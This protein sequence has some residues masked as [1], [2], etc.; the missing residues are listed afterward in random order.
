MYWFSFKNEKEA[1]KFAELLNA[2]RIYATDEKDNI[3]LKSGSS[4]DCVDRMRNELNTFAENFVENDDFLKSVPSVL[5]SDDELDLLFR[6]A[7]VNKKNIF[8]VATRLMIIHKE[9]PCILKKEKA[10]IFRI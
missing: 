9:L 7:Y 1:E 6:D 4:K 3:V 10:N 8:L 5:L 2:A